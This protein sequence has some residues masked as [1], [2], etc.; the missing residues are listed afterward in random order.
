MECLTE[1]QA[2]AIALDDCVN[3]PQTLLSHLHQAQELIG[4]RSGQIQQIHPR[5]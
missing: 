5:L 4:I 1:V 3:L 2:R